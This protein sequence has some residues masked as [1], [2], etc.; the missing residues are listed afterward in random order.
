[1]KI[2]THYSD[3]H[4]D[5]YENY[6]KKSIRD[7]YT[8]DEL[9]IRSACHKQTTQ[10]GKFMEQGWL[11]SMKYKLQ[12]ILQ[13]IEENKD[14]Y[15]IFSDVDIYYYDRFLDDLVESVRD[16]DIACQ[17]DCGTLCA[18]FFIA[19]SND[20]VKSLFEKVYKTFTTLVNDQVALNHHKDMVNFKLLDKEKYFTI[21][22]FFN[23]DDGT[24]IWDNSSNIIP[25]ANML[26]HHGNYVQGVDNKINLMQMVKANYEN[27]V[28]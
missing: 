9:I 17:E 26:I 22:N 3:S 2:Y 27:L 16:Y 18:G 14:D 10:S 23:N 4:R 1:M 21:G 15:F 13:A 6:F 25:P 28:R 24:H 11:E 8:K 5:L 7:L 20:S 19:K 12:V